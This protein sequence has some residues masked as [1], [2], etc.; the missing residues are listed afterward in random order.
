LVCCFIIFVTRFFSRFDS[1]SFFESLLRLLTCS[2]PWFQ[3]LPA[4]ASSPTAA[5]DERKKKE[6]DF[7]T[8]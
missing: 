5:V 1:L 4:T 3:M 6:K 7:L 8:A 2:F